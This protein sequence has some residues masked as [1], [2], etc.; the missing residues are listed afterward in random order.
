MEPLTF[1]VAALGGIGVLICRPLM[2]LLIYFAVLLWFPQYLSVK[3]G[4]IDFTSGRIVIMALYLKLFTSTLLPKRLRWCWLD[5]LILISMGM[6]MFAGAVTMFSDLVGVLEN[7]F[8]S[9]FDIV[10]PY[11][12]ARMILTSRENLVKFLKGLLLLACPLALVGGYQCLTGH[13]PVGFMRAYAG[14]GTA[15][16]T[17]LGHHMRFGLYRSEVTFSHYIMFGLFYAMVGVWFAGLWHP[18][19]RNRRSGRNWLW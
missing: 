6:E 15:Y 1:G 16:Y 10:L 9:A 7:R 8:G 2:G 14:W 5:K 17:D 12:A 19:K 3:L 13:N 18:M 4:T 11:F